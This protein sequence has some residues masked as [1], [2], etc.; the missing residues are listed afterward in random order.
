MHVLLCC[1]QLAVGAA[2]GGGVAGENGQL[3]LRS[4]ASST[5]HT[6]L[7]K[8]ETRGQLGAARWR[9]VGAPALPNL[10]G[11]LDLTSV[12]AGDELDPAKLLSRLAV[13]G[14]MGG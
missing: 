3:A 8:L 7:P 13:G 5:L 4:L 2:A 14:W 9:L 6:L 10:L 12:A 11:M 1:H